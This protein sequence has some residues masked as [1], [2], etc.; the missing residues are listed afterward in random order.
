M[1]DFLVTIL[2]IVCVLGWLGV[3]YLLALQTALYFEN[4]NTTR[5]WQFLAA[6]ILTFAM[7]LVVLV[8]V[9]SVIF[10]FVIVFLIA[11]EAL[12]A[13]ICISK[14]GKPREP[15]TSE[16]AVVNVLLATSMILMIVFGWKT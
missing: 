3:S 4:K 5:G 13:L 12:E 11:L 6:T 8:A 9:T 16:V 15:V 1:S 2:T 10:K 7:P 14:I